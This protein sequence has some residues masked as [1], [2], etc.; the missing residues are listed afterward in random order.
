M[1]DLGLCFE[2]KLHFNIKWHFG[3]CCA[4]IY[5]IDP[6][7]KLSEFDMLVPSSGE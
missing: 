6:V 5:T 2:E 4:V 1:I 3:C 7:L